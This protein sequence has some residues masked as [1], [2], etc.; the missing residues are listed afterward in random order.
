MT[1]S[2]QALETQ[3]A[4]LA[5]VKEQ[6][7]ET[8]LIQLH[9]G[10]EGFNSPNNFGIYKSTGGEPLGVVGGTFAPQN[11]NLIFEVLTLSMV[12]AD[13][14]LSTLKFNEYKGGQ[15]VEFSA[16]LADYTYD[17]SPI[18]GD[19]VSREINLRV[20]LNGRTKTTLNTYANRL[21]C[22]NG[23]TE[24]VDQ[25]IVGFKNTKG[26]E[27]RAPALCGQLVETAK[28]SLEFHETLNRFLDRKVSTSQ[29]TNYL[30][31]LLGETKFDELSTRKKNMLDDINQ[32]VAIEKKA[33][34]ANLFAL[35]Q[36]VTRWTT[37]EM[38]AGNVEDI[39]FSKVATYN[40]KAFE[41]GVQMLSN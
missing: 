33:L 14:D 3:F 29:A 30:L 20:G 4:N 16:K 11:L 24:K 2:I 34:G 1:T 10:L 27:F 8:K 22:S 35:Y 23:C 21:W 7:F 41:L 5:I 18:V 40:D 17:R 9:S 15:I 38:A 19:I 32:C 25:T 36:G 13:L 37:H 6:L 31:R 39:K 26:N 28:K 12:N